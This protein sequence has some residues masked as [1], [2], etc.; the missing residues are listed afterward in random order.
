VCADVAEEPAA[1]IIRAI[2]VGSQD[3]TAV[4]C[5]MSLLSSADVCMHLGH[6]VLVIVCVLR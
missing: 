5:W 1:T 4:L 6:E 2:E 3:G